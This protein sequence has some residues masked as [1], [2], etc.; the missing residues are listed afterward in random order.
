MCFRTLFG[1]SWAPRGPTLHVGIRGESRCT[2]TADSRPSFPLMC[3]LGVLALF[4]LGTRLLINNFCVHGDFHYYRDFLRLSG[5]FFSWPYV[6]PIILSE[7][8]GNIRGTPSPFLRLQQA[9]L[10]ETSRRWFPCIPPTLNPVPCPGPYGPFRGLA[11]GLSAWA[12]LGPT[13]S[14]I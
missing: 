6:W 3:F 12:K 4:P 14:I 11:G 13:N 5:L 9:L 2:K 1:S 7:P 10:L 8:S